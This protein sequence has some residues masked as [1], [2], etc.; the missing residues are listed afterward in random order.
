MYIKYMFRRY[1]KIKKDIKLLNIIM[2]L[3]KKKK[4]YITN[5]KIYY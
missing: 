5:L 2:I 4:Q 3:K 1:L